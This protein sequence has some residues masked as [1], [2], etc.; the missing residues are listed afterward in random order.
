MGPLEMLF[1]FMTFVPVAFGALL[2]LLDLTFEPAECERGL[3]VLWPFTWPSTVRLK[4]FC[5]GAPIAPMT[6]SSAPSS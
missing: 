2:D 5:F 6:P 3:A 1:A 4:F